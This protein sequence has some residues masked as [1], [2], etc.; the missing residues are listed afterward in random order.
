ME[1]DGSEGRVGEKTDYMIY[2]EEIVKEQ[3]EL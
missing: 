3:I 2:M 1:V